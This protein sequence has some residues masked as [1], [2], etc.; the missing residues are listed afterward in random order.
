MGELEVFLDSLQKQ[1]EQGLND[2]NKFEQTVIM[3]NKNKHLIDQNKDFKYYTTETENYKEPF[4][5]KNRYTTICSTCKWTCHQN[6]IYQNNSDKMKCCAMNG[7]GFCRS[8]PAKCHWSKHTNEP[9]VWKRR[10]KKVANQ[11][12]IKEEI[13]RWSEQRK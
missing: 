7:D 13:F 10:E 4:S 6:C 11:S 8:C 9:F 5:D 2:L 1:L 12:R 3:V